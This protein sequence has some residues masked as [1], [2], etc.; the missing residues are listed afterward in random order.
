MYCFESRVRYSETNEKGL[1]S[2]AALVDYL[3]DCCTFQSEDLDVGL[4]YLRENRIGWFITS[5]DIRIRR[6]PSLGERITVATWPYAFRGFLGSRNFTV[7]TAEGETL[8]EA[9]SLWILMDL[10]KGA[11]KRLPQ[12][13]Q[14]AFALEAPLQSNRRSGK[15]RVS[16]EAQMVR[17]FVVDRTYVDTNHHMNNGYYVEAAAGELPDGLRVREILVEYKKPAVLGDR[18]FCYR[19]T[20]Q[21]ACRILLGNEDRE[22]YAVVEFRGE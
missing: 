22:S 11:P 1:L 17:E 4:P 12:K 10:E 21:N 2:Y 8:A 5:W 20:E 18:L 14:E 19:E 6:L 16:P 9:D 15:L 3:Q 13:M 7:R